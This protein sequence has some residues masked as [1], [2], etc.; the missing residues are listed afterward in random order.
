MDFH[1]LSQK[2]K[3]FWFVKDGKCISYVRSIHNLSVSEGLNCHA[4]LSLVLARVKLLVGLLG[5]S[6]LLMEKRGTCIIWGLSSCD[7]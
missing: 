2:R 1:S 4:S 6:L 7:G 3:V 5:L